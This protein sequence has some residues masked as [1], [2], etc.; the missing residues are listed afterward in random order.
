MKII[1]KA[2]MNL[3]DPFTR[4]YMPRHEQKFY[5]KKRNVLVQY[6]YNIARTPIVMKIP[7]DNPELLLTQKT[8]DFLRKERPL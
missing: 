3:N 2:L 4:K 5:N 6:L 8:I 1:Q 7:K